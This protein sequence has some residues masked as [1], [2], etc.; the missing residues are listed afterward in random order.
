MKLF[1][2]LKRK[3]TRADLVQKTKDELDVVKGQNA[4]LVHII[5]DIV[6][7]R[8]VNLG[9]YPII[10]QG[11]EFYSDAE[12]DKN[13]ADVAKAVRITVDKL[14]NLPIVIERK[15]TQD[16]KESWIEDTDHELNLLFEQPNPF[17][18]NIDFLTHIVQCLLVTAKTH[19]Q[20][21]IQIRQVKE[22]WPIQPWMIKMERDKNTGHPTG[23]TL[24]PYGKKIPLKLA[25][26]L[27]IQSYHMSD[28]FSPSFPLTP[29]RQEAL[30]IYH[31]I[32]YNRRYFENGAQPDILFEDADGMSGISDNPEKMNMFLA[33]FDARNAGVSNSHKRGVLPPGVKANIVDNPIKDMMFDSLI[34][35]YRE[36]ILGFFGIP[37]TEAGIMEFA[38]YA[39]ALLEKK[40]FWENRL[41]PMKKRIEAAINRQIVW[42]FYSREIRFRLDESHIPALQEDKNQQATIAV[43]LFNAGIIKKNEAR[44]IVGLEPD[45][46]GDDYKQVP[47]PTFG[48]PP[49]D[50][51]GETNDQNRFALPAAV[52]KASPI[53]EYK[54]HFFSRLGH[55]EDKYANMI[56]DYF[57]GQKRRILSHIQEVT[58]RGLLMG[59]LYIEAKKL[60]C[61]DDDSL[62]PEEPAVLFSMAME[63]NILQRKVEPFTEKLIKDSGEEILQLANIDLSFNVD[64]PWVQ[65]EITRIW[66]RS[67][68]MND[69]TFAQIRDLLRQAYEEDWSLGQLENAIKDTYTGWATGSPGKQSRAMTIARTETNSVVSGGSNQ[70]MIQAGLR[71]VWFAL[72]GARDSHADLA[73][74]EPIGSEEY[75]ITINGDMLRYPGDPNGSAKEVVNCRCATAPAIT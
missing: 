52:V 66:N 61:K 18:T 45:E 60:E 67:K 43:N 46:G 53:D 42:P 9:G 65:E 24:D 10:F 63:N 21:I 47:M 19:F 36:Q 25:E 37:P 64:N 6:P 62:P 28:P 51:G 41:I 20:K 11:S 71:K 3:I 7:Q 12:M 22:L 8:I 5:K 15:T 26:V 34:K 54:K 17:H 30:S 39:N 23:F 33:S 69:A 14:A 40:S 35:L 58:Q 38:S 59:M 74:R 50:Q 73:S 16:G 48:A 57:L 44:E 68:K 1:D 4:R 75:W 27:Y 70:A 31:A 13:D 56:S 49:Q 32:G 55:Y 29:I 72:P 2:N